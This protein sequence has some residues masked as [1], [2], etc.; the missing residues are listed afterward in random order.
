[1]VKEEQN[2]L[3]NI[4]HF[5]L[6]SAFRRISNE[7]GGS[8]IYVKEYVQTKERNCLQELCIEKRL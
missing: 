4:D 8:C 7:H 6:V 5:K 3:T 1:L 2:G